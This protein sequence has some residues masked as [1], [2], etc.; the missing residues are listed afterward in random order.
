MQ[1]VT[2]NKKSGA[3]N[4]GLYNYFLRLLQLTGKFIT[5][6]LYATIKF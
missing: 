4:S 1:L 2:K 6:W 5:Q 3:F